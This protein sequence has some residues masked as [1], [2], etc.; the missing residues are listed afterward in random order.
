MSHVTDIKI[1]GDFKVTNLSTLEAAARRCG[2]VLK[3]DQKTFQSYGH[4][5]PPCTHAIGLTEEMKRRFAAVNNSHGGNYA[6]YEI[7]VLSDKATQGEESFGLK[8]DFFGG[9]I[10][11][12]AGKNLDN[13]LMYYQAESVRKAAENEGYLYSDQM[14][15]NG[16]LVATVDTTVKLGY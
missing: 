1:K 4:S 13:L 10:E 2:M 8:C 5:R 6:D 12:A 3:R 16:E 7:G 15:P 9:G 14:M 11:F